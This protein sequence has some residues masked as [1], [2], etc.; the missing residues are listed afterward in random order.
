M[1]EYVELKEKFLEFIKSDVPSL[2]SANEL[3]VLLDTFPNISVLCDLRIDFA[4]YRPEGGD[5]LF[6]GDT[7]KRK[8]QRTLEY[9]NTHQKTSP[10]YG[11]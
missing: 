10:Y 3:E 8:V 2:H 7:I 11:K 9:L 6:D 1:C 5:Y 4:S